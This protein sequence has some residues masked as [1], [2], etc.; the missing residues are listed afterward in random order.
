MPAQ[1]LR[2]AG[3]LRHAVLDSLNGF[4]LLTESRVQLCLG[5]A[6]YSSGSMQPQPCTLPCVTTSLYL[7]SG[8]PIFLS[9]CEK[10]NVVQNDGCGRV[11]LVSASTAFHVPPGPAAPRHVIFCKRQPL[12]AHPH[13]LGRAARDVQIVNLFSAPA[14]VAP[15]SIYGFS[16]FLRPVLVM[17]QCMHFSAVIIWEMAR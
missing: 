14:K 7:H 3:C 8:I 6:L 4:H 13:K 10:C 11:Q 16:C 5:P 17:A 15:C 12:K 1:K 2:L 9:R